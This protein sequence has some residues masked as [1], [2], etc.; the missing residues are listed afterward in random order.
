MLEGI[1]GAGE[2]RLKGTFFVIY[3]N[4]KSE[5]ATPKCIGIF[6]NTLCNHISTS[7]FAR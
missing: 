7:T 2:V 6:G 1:A 5:K 4:K 3:E